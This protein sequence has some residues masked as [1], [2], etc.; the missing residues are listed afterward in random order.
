M[1]NDKITILFPG[2]FK[3]MHAGHIDLINRYSEDPCVNEIQILVGPGTR[4]DI[5]QAVAVCIAQNLLTGALSDIP[6]KVVAVSDNTPMT[7]AY[8]FMEVA[9][10]GTYAMAA[11]SKEAENS[12][13]IQRFVT[14]HNNGKYK[15]P[16][17]VKVVEMPV[18]VE[19]L[20]YE[21]RNDNNN[22]K[23]ISA[24]VLRQDLIDNNFENFKTNY[25]N[26]DIDTI[27]TVWNLLK[28]GG[29]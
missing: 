29:E 13:R 28:Y 8:K 21:E 3:P 17:D 2:A 14:N 27:T 10:P 25:P 23:P 18:N 9:D 6:I 1:K 12:Q 19:P 4:G 24:S 26:F 15:L 22:G 11:S 7:T 5:D 20:I 16:E